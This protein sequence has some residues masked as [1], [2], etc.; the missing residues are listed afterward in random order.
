[1]ERTVVLDGKRYAV[2]DVVRQVVLRPVRPEEVGRWKALI[3]QHH[4]LGLH[5]LVGETI[6]HVAEVD[7]HWVALLGW[8]SAALKVTVRD[9][10]IGWTAQQKKRR[11]K[12][13]AQNG[14]FL[15]LLDPQDVPNL[16]SRVLALSVRRLAEDWRAVYGHPVVLAETFVDPRR[17]PGTCYRAAGWQ[18]LGETEGYGKHAM[19]YME[20]GRP[21]QY[22]IRPLFRGA[23]DWLRQPFDVPAL[24]EQRS[25][26]DPN[27]IPLSGKEGLLATLAK[28]PDRRN[29]RGI[30]HSQ[31]SILAVAVCGV[32]AGSRGFRAI[33]DFAASLD[34]EALLR[35]GCRRSLNTGELRPPSEP[36]IRR[37]LT[38]IDADALDRL[39]GEFLSRAG[40]W[41][42]VAVDG[43]T[44]RGSGRDEHKPQHLMAAVTHKTPVTLAQRPVG[45]TTNEI[46]E[47]CSLLAPL[48][49]RGKVVT[50]DAMHTQTELAR[51]LVEDKGA[52]YV[53][54]VKDNQ[55]LLRKALAASDWELS[56]PV[57]GERK[58]PRPD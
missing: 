57:H 4:Y 29:R 6:L 20:H 11:L 36:T 18:C 24:S 31:A 14:R 5:H 34:G 26:V 12:F 3:R 19:V 2:S 13:I 44:L 40:L 25:R 32:L 15:M 23:E 1:M 54:T 9:R 7:G 37:T 55:S 48:D 56:P 39:V 38:R 22:L 46:G 21:K 33:A 53:F 41:E 58:R 8:C 28:V 51:F 43:K 27:C 35:L 30:R 49:L 16:A 50:A 45:A 47:A 42:A 52:D 10:F 17:F